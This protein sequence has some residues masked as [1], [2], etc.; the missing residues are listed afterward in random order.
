VEFLCPVLDGRQH[1][2]LRREPFLS[3]SKGSVERL[4]PSLVFRR[5][6]GYDLFQATVPGSDLSVATHGACILFP[7][8]RFQPAAGLLGNFKVLPLDICSFLWYNIGRL[9]CKTD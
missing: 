3:L 2:R 5:K 6:L 9:V 8:G 1:I 7:Y 4:R